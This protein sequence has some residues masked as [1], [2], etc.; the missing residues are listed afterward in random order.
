MAR[1]TPMMQQYLQIKEQFK[2]SIL[3]FRMGDFYEMFFEDAIIASKDLEITLTGKDCGLS[4]RAPMCGVPHHASEQYIAKLIEKGHKVAI[5]EQVQD[6][7]EA[8][9]LV[10]RQVVRVV[11]PGTLIESSM[12]DDKINN[13]LLA[14]FFADST[15]GLSGVDI[16]TG[17]F[18]LSQI[19]GDNLDS[20]LI[21]EINRINPS[22]I[23]VQESLEEVKILKQAKDYY[24]FYISRYKDWAFDASNAY[25]KLIKQFKVHSL[26][27]FGCEEMKAGIRAA[28]ALLEY[29]TDTQKST[30]AQIN[31]LKVYHQKSYMILDSTAMRNLELSE[32]IRN[33]DKKGSLLW[34]L[35]KTNTAMGGRLLRKWIHQPLINKKDIEDRL[36][37]IEELIN[38]QDILL[39][40]RDKL[41]KI[42]DIERL[43]SRITYG[44]ANA[45][46]M[47]SLK[48]SLEPLPEIKELLSKLTSALFTNYY[49]SF[50]VLDDIYNLLE[51]SIHTDP[52]ITIRE[53]NIIK[54]GYDDL[55]DSYRAAMTEGKT[56]IA[57]ME[58]SEREKTGIK[59]LKIGFNKVFG[60]YIDITHSNKDLVPDSYI[61]KQTLVNSERYITPELKEIEDRILGAEEKSAKLEYQIFTNIRSQVSDH[62]VRIQKTAQNI[63]VLDVLCSLTR[64]S[65]ENNYTK[66]KILTTGEI[67]IKDGR[68]PVVE[69]SLSDDMFVPND[70]DLDT[71][72]AHLMVITGPNMAGKSTY[73]RQVALIVIMAQIGCFVPA[74]QAEIGIVDRVFTRVGASDDLSS[75]QSTFMVEMSEVANILN[76]LTANSLLVLDEIG[77]GTSTF[78]GLSIAWAVIEHLCSF[79]KIKPR[80]MFA[81]HYHELT[82]LEGR[83]EGIKN[84]CIAVKEHGDDIIFLRKIIRGGADKSFGLQVAKL[85]GI[86][87]PI[88]ERANKI[89][90]QLEEADINKQKK[91]D[92]EL[93]E[94]NNKPIVNEQIGFFN[95]GFT[96]IE[97][98]LL[99]IDILNLT[100]M[101]AMETL[102][103]L[104]ERAKAKEV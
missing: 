89:L 53:G 88:I 57:S 64:V 83:I 24:G 71:K 54:E 78:D 70:T 59:N 46:D 45:R 65:Y 75:G 20:K 101:Q 38:R 68:H 92:K 62:V 52:P 4:E 32:T 103:K 35:D 100:P 22:E 85:A 48:Q 80:T 25:K 28:G 84:Y 7:S 10:E 27:G 102:Y 94:T 47:L 12:L 77:R 40:L 1:L 91:R 44:S 90:R 5:C 98:D 8:K 61:R 33:K 29:L 86:P 31:M 56:W 36:N 14:L 15:I 104:I 81:T 9:G 49:E 95:E 74:S 60:Y 43:I 97:K 73:M 55:L 87:N 26:K 58:E 50:D 37:S 11:T 93:G 51:K 76:N 19:T 66:P 67:R 79:D 2:D 21:D 72:D 23:I 18:F 96:D 63:A 41:S 16:S 6:P 69:K 34:L 99:E 13:Y 3:F 17:E 30:L 39:Q 82:E 42:Y